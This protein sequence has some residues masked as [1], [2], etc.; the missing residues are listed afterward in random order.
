MVHKT[1]LT[2]FTLLLTVVTGCPATA[3]QL[4]RVVSYRD[5]DLATN[6]GVRTFR[7]RLAH[8]VNYVCRFA[9]AGGDMLKSEN[10]QCRE[11]VAAAIK[12]KMTRAIEL[13]QTRAAAIELAAR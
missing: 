12:P 11:D 7:H 4:T 3:Q 10:Q 13:A 5:L 9:Y 8:A 2:A 6:Q 1:A